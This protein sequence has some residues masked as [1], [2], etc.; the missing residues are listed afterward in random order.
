MK[1]TFNVGEVLLEI[2][3]LDTLYTF[4][5]IEVVLEGNT[6]GARLPSPSIG[7]DDSQWLAW[8]NEPREVACGYEVMTA[9]LRHLLALR[10]A[11]RG[12]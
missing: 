4:N 6:L 8:P 3:G 9:R 10:L 11:L 1:S 7:S 12:S 2:I 5:A